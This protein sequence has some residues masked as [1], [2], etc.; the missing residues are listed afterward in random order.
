MSPG[1]IVGCLSLLVLD[2]QQHL[3]LGFH[4]FWSYR[5]ANALPSYFLS[6]RCV[7][8]DVRCARALFLG[9]QKEES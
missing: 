8:C 7:S 2:E 9:L 6:S 4:C 5:L 1:V 3:A